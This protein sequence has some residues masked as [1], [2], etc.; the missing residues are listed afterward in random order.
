MKVGVYTRVIL[1]LIIGILF[2]PRL[3]YS[4]SSLSLVDETVDHQQ[5]YH[6]KHSV[7]LQ[8]GDFTL[9]RYK[10]RPKHHPTG[11][12]PG[13]LRIPV[14]THARDQTLPVEDHLPQFNR[15][16]DVSVNCSSNGF[17]LRVKRSFYGFTAAPEELTLGKT[18]KSNGVLEPHNDLLFIYALTDCQGENQSN[19]P[20]FRSHHVNV[21]VECRIKRHHVHSEVVRPTWRVSLHKSIRSRLADFRIQLMDD[22]WS[23]PVRSAVH[24]L[25]QRVNVQISTQHQNAGVKLFISSCYVTT[26]QNVHQATNYSIIDNFGCLRESLINPDA[27]FRFSKAD[28]IVQFS[29]NAFQF[30]DASDAKVSL[31]CELSVSGGGP[32]PVQKSCFYNHV[33]NRWISVSGH[34]SVCDCCDSVC[35]HT[36]TK[37][38]IY[39]GFGFVS[40]DQVGF[41]DPVTSPPS[42]F[43]SSTLD[44]IVLTHNNV[45]AIWF[46]AKWANES[47]R[48]H[49]HNDFAASVTLSSSEDHFK[50]QN[51]S[52]TRTVDFIE[53]VK[54]VMEVENQ[55]DVEILM[56]TSESFVSF[57][58]PKEITKFKHKG[59]R[60]KVHETME[61]AASLG[62]SE[63]RVKTNLVKGL[64]TDL[65]KGKALKKMSVVVGTME[66]NFKMDDS[67]LGDGETQDL[68]L[69]SVIAEEEDESST[70]KEENVGF[71][72]LSE[73]EEKSEFPLGLD[74]LME[75]GVV[76]K[77]DFTK[78]PD[79]YFNSEDL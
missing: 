67:T 42:T 13:L 41:A 62:Q 3:N 31:H 5:T 26:T 33:T 45:D 66:E 17:V 72:S 20:H 14:Q 35:N 23:S 29:F 65:G 25:G 68:I 47:Q 54:E 1:N 4:V 44:S 43:A 28:N 30:I 49:T 12:V 60:Q 73:F 8:R 7:E 6:Q 71:V 70:N 64:K 37:R 78:D 48:S 21:G 57:E 10:V 19:R 9:A 55:G 2:S 63:H 75:Q 69:S 18:C 46:E 79:Y 38:L 34:D 16:P 59:T 27:R 58:R 40:S 32:S 24:M 11:S 52:H 61:H 36:K 56:A 74:D 77:M 50:T 51:E 15:L 22:S 39:E 53:E 76:R